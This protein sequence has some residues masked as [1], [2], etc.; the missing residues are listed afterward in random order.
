MQFVI[1]IAGLKKYQTGTLRST[2]MMMM[3]ISGRLLD[4]G[5]DARVEAKDLSY[6]IDR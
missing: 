6:E 1:V 3:N 4:R 2:T 5:L